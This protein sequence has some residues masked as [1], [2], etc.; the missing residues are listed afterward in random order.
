[1]NTQNNAV[2][3]TFVPDFFAGMEEDTAFTRS[4][5]PTKPDV[6][7]ASSDI[8]HEPAMASVE[9]ETI[10]T[11]PTVEE[12]AGYLKEAVS[13]AANPERP[14]S[15][16]A[17]GVFLK[18]YARLVN[19]NTE[20]TFTTTMT[21]KLFGSYL[22]VLSWFTKDEIVARME[23]VED[24][25]AVKTELMTMV[26]ENVKTF[27]NGGDYSL[28]SI[29][30]AIKDTIAKAAVKIFGDSVPSNVLMAIDN[31]IEVALSGV[32]LYGAISPAFLREHAE[33][34]VELSNGK[35]GKSLQWKQLS[36]E[37]VSVYIEALDIV[38]RDIDEDLSPAAL[39]YVKSF[40][41]RVNR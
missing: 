34:I 19:I 9:T 32:M 24:D 35:V 37:E 12:V 8:A 15:E 36:I 21:A 5:E 11:L 7:P 16:R 31:I 30:K 1:M 6:S 18:L 41:A 10:T 2:T 39:E 28:S 38:V 17:L 20:V 33:I 22:K 25:Y 40:W 26:K 23:E 29:K 14:E 13:A 27:L 3:E 4:Y